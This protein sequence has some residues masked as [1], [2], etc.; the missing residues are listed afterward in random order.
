[1]TKPAHDITRYTVI[2]DEWE[3]PC[4]HPDCWRFHQRFMQRFPDGKSYWEESAGKFVDRFHMMKRYHWLIIDNETGHR[5]FEGEM[6]DTKAEATKDLIRKTD[7]L[8]R[9]AASAH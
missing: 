1:M 2:R 8:M 4:E 6:Y 3:M 9:L 5:A 7:D